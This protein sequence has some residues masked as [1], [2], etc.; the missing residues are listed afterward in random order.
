MGHQ[1]HAFRVHGISPAKSLSRDAWRRGAQLSS[2]IYASATGTIPVY[3]DARIDRTLG[4][5]AAEGTQMGGFRRMVGILSLRERRDNARAA[6]S[7]LTLASRYYASRLPSAST[8]SPTLRKSL[9]TCC[10]SRRHLPPRVTADIFP[11]E[12]SFSLDN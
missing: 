12:L 6:T 1:V 10:L 8:V 11:R 2:G 4:P 9:S 5:R 3:R 7:C